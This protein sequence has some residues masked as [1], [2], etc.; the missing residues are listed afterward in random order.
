M[1]AKRKSKIAPRRNPFSL[2]YFLVCDD[3][4]FEKSGK[5]I[6]IGVYADAIVISAA[7]ARLPHLSFVFCVDRLGE[8]FPTFGTFALDGPEGTVVNDSTFQFNVTDKTARTSNLVFH[9]AGLP[10]HPGEYRARLN[11]NGEQDFVGEFRVQVNPNAI[12]EAV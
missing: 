10:L 8:P 12:A 9:T 4:R 11:V 2:R 6:L 5:A 7:G 1:A 3:A